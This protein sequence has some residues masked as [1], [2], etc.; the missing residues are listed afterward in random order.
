M[1]VNVEADAGAPSESI[2]FIITW[3]GFD[4]WRKRD[5]GH[6]FERFGKDL[7]FKGTLVSEVDVTE[8]G[9]PSSVVWVTVNACRRPHVVSTVPTRRNNLHCFCAPERLL[10]VIGDA[11]KYAFT[12]D[13]VG[14]KN[15]TTIVTRDTDTPVR[16]VGN[17]YFDHSAKPFTHL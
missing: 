7:R 10:L 4:D 9:T 11:H 13:R 12:G 6:A 14:N 3:H 2:S 8:L 15:D 1:F 17:V 16:N 5:F